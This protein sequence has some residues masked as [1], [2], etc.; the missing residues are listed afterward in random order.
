MG[1]LDGG[2]VL[3]GAVGAGLGGVQ[4]LTIYVLQGIR[5]HLH[6]L[7]SSVQTLTNRVALIEGRLERERR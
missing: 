2:D 1:P 7:R 4:G 3:L 6:D 5:Q